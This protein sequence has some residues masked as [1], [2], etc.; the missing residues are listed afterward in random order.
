[1]NLIRYSDIILWAAECEVEVGSLATAM[2]L[3]NKVRARAQITSGWVYLNSA[4]DAS[5][6]IYTTQTTPAANYKVG[7]YTIFPDQAYARKAVRFERKIELAMEGHRFFDLQRWGSAYQAAEINAFIA[8]DKSIDITL[9]DAHFTQNQDE[10]RPIPQ[11][12]IDISNS[13]GPIVLKQ[14]PGY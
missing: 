5:K 14:N 9:K 6:S 1:V 7:L 11:A 13:K 2:T 12:Q 8:S 10:Y 3:V 4:Y